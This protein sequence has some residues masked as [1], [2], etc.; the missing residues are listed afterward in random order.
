MNPHNLLMLDLDGTIRRPKGENKFI[1]NPK[2][3][4][5]F[6]EVLGLLEEYRKADFTIVGITNQGGVAAGFKSI[7][8]CV[9]EQKYTL[10]LAPQ[11][12]CI[13]FCPSKRGRSC[14]KVNRDGSVEKYA[15]NGYRKP[16]PGMLALAMDEF[17]GV[18]TRNH[19]LYEF[20][21][22]EY[23]IYDFFDDWR[24]YQA[25]G[26]NARIN[27]TLPDLFST[28][29][30]YYVG[31]RKEDAQAVLGAC[32]P[33]VEAERWRGGVAYEHFLQFAKK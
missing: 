25:W 26:S 15:G 27:I 12:D 9:A 33:M 21:G 30:V 16:H 31:D 32:V 11:M 13:Y 22:L 1:N 8:N 23:E 14:R 6:P 28:F 10:E 17:F 3:Q 19:N 29:N 24:E 4:E 7:E 20:D 5:L 18:I 2:D